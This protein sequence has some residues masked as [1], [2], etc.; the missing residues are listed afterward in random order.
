LESPTAGVT[1]CV[2]KEYNL[3]GYWYT[4]LIGLGGVASGWFMGFL[5]SPYNDKEGEKFA[6]VA[7]L[8]SVFLSGYLL[9]QLES[10][11]KFIFQE[12]NS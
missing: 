5:V 10:S 12:R 8:I 7:S 4:I 2:H 11:V 3:C 9:S 1:Y 6:K